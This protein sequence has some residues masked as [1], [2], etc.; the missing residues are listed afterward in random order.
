MCAC[1]SARA[2]VC[3]HMRARVRV[4][5]RVYVCARVCVQIHQMEQ[6]V[7]SARAE[8]SSE[9]QQQKRLHS[10]TQNELTQV[11]Y[12]SHKCMCACMHV[13]MCVCMIV[14]MHVCM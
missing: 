3:M 1:V 8:A 4:C 7:A 13:R 12:R 10:A 5:T 2:C 9:L 6:L 11:H 14:C